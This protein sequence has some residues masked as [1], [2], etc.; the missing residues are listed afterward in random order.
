MSS[1]RNLCIAAILLPCWASAEP[2]PPADPAA[3]RA[4][5]LERLKV[6]KVRFD[7][8]SLHSAAMDAE[9]DLVATLLDAG[10]DPNA[11][12]VI[13]PAIQSALSCEGRPADPE[14]RLATVEVLLA[15][16]A[17]ATWHDGNR[18]NLL[19]SAVACPPAV[20]ERLLAAGAKIDEQN[21][22]GFGPLE[23]ALIRGKWAVAELLIR[24]GARVTQAEVDQIFFE[25]P[26]DSEKRAIL[27]R[28]TG[29]R[30]APANN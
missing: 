13:G 5:A 1:L 29:P 2:A 25:L 28:A 20:V 21:V 3:T 14:Q 15:H 17:D 23:G 4:A 11:S 22:L 19:M 8:Q 10:L 30:D 12:G 7:P 24:Q 6:L 16:G 26:S 18:N 27:A 9:A